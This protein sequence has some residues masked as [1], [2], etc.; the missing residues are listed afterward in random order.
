MHLK[1]NMGSA[2]RATTRTELQP[3]SSMPTSVSSFAAGIGQYT[4]TEPVPPKP[5]QS[6]PA[7]AASKSIDTAF[8]TAAASLSREWPFRP[9]PKSNLRGLD[10]PVDGGHVY[11]GLPKPAGKPIRFLVL[12][13]AGDLQHLGSRRRL[14]EM[15]LVDPQLLDVNF[16]LGRSKDRAIR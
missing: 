1:Q 2:S 5:G 7:L 13:G 6:A 3:I 14:A 10:G 15:N 16:L 11:Q 9:G 8:A 12:L 4:T